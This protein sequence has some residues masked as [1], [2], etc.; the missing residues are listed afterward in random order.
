MQV[1]I[2]LSE[3]TVKTACRWGK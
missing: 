1:D 2:F 3:S